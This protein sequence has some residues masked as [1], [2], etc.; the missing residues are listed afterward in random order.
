MLKERKL[1]PSLV[2]ALWLATSLIGAAQSG[3]PK[4][5]TYQWSGELVAVDA[6]A[7]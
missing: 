1:V 3:A 6:T 5:D 2:C 7:S 4:Q